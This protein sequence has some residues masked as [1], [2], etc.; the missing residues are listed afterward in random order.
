VLR[1]R[2]NKTESH[3]STKHTRSPVAER[4]AVSS[5]VHPDTSTRSQRRPGSPFCQIYS[6]V[7]ERRQSILQFYSIAEATMQSTLPVHQLYSI[8]EEKNQYILTADTLT[9]SQ[10]P[11][12]SPDHSVNQPT[13]PPP[14]PSD[15]SALNQI[16]WASEREEKRREGPFETHSKPIRKPTLSRHSWSRRPWAVKWA[17]S[18]VNI[19]RSPSLLDHGGIPTARFHSITKATL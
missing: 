16:T 13:R 5:V 19:Y 17:R 18:R 15:Q 6:T 10:R 7:E 4:E 8:A 11:R 1:K 2:E 12:S 14:R 3:T 9:R